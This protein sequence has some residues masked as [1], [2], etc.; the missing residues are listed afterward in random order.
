[1]EVTKNY[2]R[3]VGT[4][5]TNPSH[6]TTIV[7]PTWVLTEMTMGAPSV[8]V[9]PRPLQDT[10]NGNPSLPSGLKSAVVG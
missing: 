4:M 7:G 2:L 8:T 3:V 9:V 5:I 6:P 1:M 10:N